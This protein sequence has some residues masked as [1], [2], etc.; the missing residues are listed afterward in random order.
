LSVALLWLLSPL[1]LVSVMHLGNNNSQET[2]DSKRFL[3]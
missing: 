1:L 2:L 3:Y